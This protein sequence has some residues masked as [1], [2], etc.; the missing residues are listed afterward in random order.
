MR[1]KYVLINAFKT[2]KNMNNNFIHKKYKAN[3]DN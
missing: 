1:K 2:L 3:N